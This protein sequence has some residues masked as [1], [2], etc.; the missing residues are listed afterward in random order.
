MVCGAAFTINL[1]TTAVNVALPTLVRELSAN[2]PQLRW[3][4]DAYNLVFATFVLAGRSLSDRFGRKGALLAGLAVFAG[5]L[6]AGRAVMGLGA[7]VI[8]PTTLSI[9]CN[10]YPGRGSAPQRLACGAPRP[11]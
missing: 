3:I 2:T 6:I 10:V 7:A 5:Q 11:A 9:L 4:V 8:Y 1:A